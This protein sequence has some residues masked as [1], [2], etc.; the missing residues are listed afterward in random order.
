[1]SRNKVIGESS[2]YLLPEAA[3]GVPVEGW[4]CEVQVLVHVSFTCSLTVF[5]LSHGVR[6]GV[7]L[8]LV[9]TVPCY[10]ESSL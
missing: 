6:L 10:P 3:E 8:M 5:K 9:D 2:W 4:S 1:M 7:R